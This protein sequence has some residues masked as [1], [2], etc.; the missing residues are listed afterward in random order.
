MRAIAERRRPPLLFLTV[1]L[2]VLA[3]DQASKA[4]AAALLQPG[5]SVSVIGQALTLT[6]THNVG[7]AFGLISQG[8]I[9]IAASSLVC[10]L[11]LGYVVA[12]GL[13]AAAGRAVAL[14]LIVGGALGNLCDRLRTGGVIDF[15]DFRVWPIFNFAD[16][17]ITVGVGVL[18]V[19]ILR[20]R[21][22]G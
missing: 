10:V 7:S 14:G 3:L 9:P 22:H 15:I 12:G 1:S 16:A 4:V 20:R 8:W 17:A 6:L 11:I 2:A 5:L 19:E 18:A 13:T 21:R